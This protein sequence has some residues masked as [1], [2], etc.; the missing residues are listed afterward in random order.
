MLD[1]AFLHFVEQRIQAGKYFNHFS[2]EHLTLI[3][4]NYSPVIVYIGSARFY[5][6]VGVVHHMVLALKP[7]LVQDANGLFRSDE[8]FLDVDGYFQKNESVFDIVV[9]VDEAA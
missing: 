4:A 5:P 8:S 3:S 2:L 6:D 7:V 9:E 1:A